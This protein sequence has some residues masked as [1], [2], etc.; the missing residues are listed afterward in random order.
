MKKLA[1]LLI[2]L[3]G[4]GNPSWDLSKPIF[5][6]VDSTTPKEDMY[7]RAATKA[8]TSIG[9]LV[10][11]DPRVSQKLSISLGGKHCDDQSVVAYTAL[12]NDHFIGVCPK[13]ATTTRTQDY[14]DDVM[15]HELGHALSGRYDHL[16]CST[17]AVMSPSVSC[18]ALQPYIKLDIDYICSNGH[19]INGKCS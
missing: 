17:L 19:T 15:K 2:L 11:Y 9:G 16:D 8:I 14:I 4:C 10:S 13:E 3:F 6:Y 5:V 1:L 18:H 7:S 12:P